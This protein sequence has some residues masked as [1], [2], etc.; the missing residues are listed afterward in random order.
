MV[1]I[2]HRRGTRDLVGR[3]VAGFSQTSPTGRIELVSM[4]T[5]RLPRSDV[6]SWE[7]SP[8]RK[9]G[10]PG[11]ST[12]PTPSSRTGLSEDARIRAGSSARNRCGFTLIELL[13]VIAIIGILIA[14]LLPAVQAAR[15][16]ARVT[17]CANNLKQMGLACIQH[18]ETHG[19]FPTCGWGYTWV[20]LPDGGFGLDQPGGWMYNLLPFVEQEAL[21]D[22]GMGGAPAQIRAGSARRV[23]TPLVFFHC[24]SRRGPILYPAVESHT[25]QPH[26]TNRV[27][28]VARHD[29]AVNGGTVK[30]NIGGPP[31]RA[32]AKTFNWPD[33]SGCNGLCHVRSQVTLAQISDGTSN[34]YLL[35]EKY[36]DPDAYL[37]GT[38]PGDNESAYC[39]HAHDII[40][41]GK[42]GWVP[43]QD[44]PGYGNASLFGSVHSGGCQ[45]VFCDGSVQLINYGI[46]GS[47]HAR[48]S[49][50]NDGRPLSAGEF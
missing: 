32:A 26:E 7:S 38:D 33:T 31:S 4:Q 11:T 20:G 16:S 17:Q 49:Q 41:W 5:R 50:R 46:D 25:R 27:T 21:H 29:Y 3:P 23:S 24:P 42:P 36:L 40:R 12:H 2:E 18:Q 35:G 30:R 10:V 45:F 13:V 28:H 9:G 14:L 43:M 8:V 44:R 22:F 37:T 47:A 39:G 48:L 1:L 15:E 6:A 34:T 19:H